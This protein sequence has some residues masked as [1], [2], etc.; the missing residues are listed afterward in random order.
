MP[1]KGIDCA[2]PLTAKTAAAIAAAGYKFAARYL[3]PPA[4]AW[5]R[6]TRAEADAIAAAGMQIVS[7]F[8]TTANRPSGGAANGKADGAAALKEAQL[9]GQPPGSAIYFACDWDAQQADFDAIEAYL[10][11]AAAQLAGYEVGVYGS[12]AVVEEMARRGAC[13]H[14]WQT[15]AWSRGKKSAK[16]NIWQY[17]NG[18]SLAGHPVDLNE[19]YGGEGWWNTKG[20]EPMTQA[21]RDALDALLRRVT[22]LE[23]D[24][25]ALKKLYEASER[26]RSMKC[27]DWARPAIEAAQKRKGPDGNPLVIDADGGSYDFYRFVS[28]LYRAGLI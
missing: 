23:E 8:E 21:E 9:I 11:A 7:V 26:Q 4:Y 14:F 16:A 5:K 24:N 2:T 3:V 1:T 28:V 13:R 25:A 12:Y 18:V 15:Y 19:S 10:R 6:L 22:K 27:P 20:D 17:K